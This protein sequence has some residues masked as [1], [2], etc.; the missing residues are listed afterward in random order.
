MEEDLAWLDE[1]EERHRRGRALEREVAEASTE[2]HVDVAPAVAVSSL[3]RLPEVAVGV[4]DVSGG[5]CPICLEDIR[6]GDL[7]TTLPCVHFFHSR[8][9]KTWLAG[10]D[11]CPVCQGSVSRGLGVSVVVASLKRPLPVSDTSEEPSQDVLRQR[12][13]DLR[14][15][16]VAGPALVAAASSS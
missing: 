14:F 5:H 11:R 4:L 1:L 13:L 6:V 3:D 16:G 7:R 9:V 2:V 8:C 15:R 10:S 12:R